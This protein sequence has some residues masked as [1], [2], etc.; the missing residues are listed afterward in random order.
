M[1]HTSERER[2]LEVHLVGVAVAALR[3]GVVDAVGDDAGDD[4]HDAHREDPD[5]ELDLDRRVLDREEDEG[6]ERDAGDAV[7]LEAVGR[8]ADRVAGVVAGA[9]G[10]DAGVTRVV[11]LDVEDDLH[12][13][14]ADV[15]DLRE[16]AAGDAERRGAERL[17]DGEADEAGAGVVAGDEQQ[18]G[19]H[20]RA[21]RR[22]EQ[23]ADAHAGLERDRVGRERLA[24]E[25][26]EGRARVREG[27]DAD[28]EP[29]D[30]VASRRCR[31]GCRTG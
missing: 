20:Q 2:G 14:G 15:G 18:D 9:V 11:F 1:S 7:G 10:D 29:G 12:Q 19:E 23:H 5:E 28:A 6:D 26:R 30:A 24:L 21:A 22:D 25:R 31:R 17:A 3:D 13:V 27:V 4:H 8:G 16:D